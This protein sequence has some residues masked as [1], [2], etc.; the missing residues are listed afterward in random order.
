MYNNGMR[1]ILLLLLFVSCSKYEKTVFIENKDKTIIEQDGTYWCWAA[2]AQAV[3]KY[4]GNE[5]AQEKVIKDFYNL[6]YI[7][8]T[9]YL[10]PMMALRVGMDGLFQS[11]Y[12]GDN[13]TFTS[14]IID[15]KNIPDFIDNNSPVVVMYSN[16]VA[17]IVG[18]RVD[19]KK[20][21]EYQIMDPG[22]KLSKTKQFLW[23]TEES[24]SVVFP[25]Y[26]SMLYGVTSLKNKQLLNI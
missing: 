21:I 6:P 23:K 3:H 16:H 8:P 24:L 1:M 25:G 19:K 5:L 14:R 13:K 4:Y 2:I 22:Y 10:S 18:Y 12:L 26:P 9:E 11:Y 7:G 20:K 17:L 15:F